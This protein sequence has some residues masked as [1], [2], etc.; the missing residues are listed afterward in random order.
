MLGIFD[1]LFPYRAS[2]FR[3]TEHVDLLE[4]FP[5]SSVYS[6][7]G[8]LSWMG[9]ADQRS[10]ILDGWYVPTNSLAS[11]LHIVESAGVVPQHDAFYMLFLNNARDFL[12]DND[13]SG[14]VFFTLYPGGGLR[15]NDAECHQVMQE[16]FKHKRFGGVI[17]TQPVVL[18][19]LMDQR[20]VPAEK[21][22]YVFG[23]VI[24]RHSSALVTPKRERKSLSVAFAAFRY[25][26]HGRDKGL[27]L[28]V[29]AIR[30]VAPRVPLDVH[31]F[32]PWSEK[33]VRPVDRNA[34]ITFHGILENQDLRSAFSEIDVAVFPTRAGILGDG[35]FDGFPT[36]AAVE[37]A[38]AGAAVI[39]TNPLAQ[40]T[41]FE[42][43]DSIIEVVPSAEAIEHWLDALWSDQSR[44]DE[45]RFR[46]QEVATSVYSYEQQMLPRIQWLKSCID[47]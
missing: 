33:D 41:P 31:F 12:R 11:R 16:V 2:G 37:A 3:L 15:F 7:L 20:L 34:Q 8:S 18:D 44:L 45:L 24:G 46:G 25:D 36:G 39:T 9:I 43:G 42:N 28:F 38:L 26:E 13:E 17:V 27:D 35:S 32:G 40:S 6:T 47:A 29:D 23:G 19:Y 10:T 5:R 1:D 22:L 21:V 4:A 30:L 14:P